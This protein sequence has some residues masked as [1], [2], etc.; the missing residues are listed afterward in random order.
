[1]K[2]FAEDLPT[3][4]ALATAA[5]AAALAVVRISGADAIR[6]ADAL[7]GGRAADA[8]EREAVLC[9]ARDASG[10][11]LDDVLMTVFHAPRSYTGE[12]LVEISGHGGMLVSRNLLARVIEC[13]AA[14][15]GPGEFTQRAFLN[16]KLDLTQA[17]AVMDIIS[18]QTDLGLRAAREQLAGRIGVLVGAAREALLGVVAHVEAHID[19]PEE[20]IDPGTGAEICDKI[21]R[22]SADI[23]RLM[24]TAE[25]GRILRE[26][27]RT[28]I[29]G[30]PNV[31]KSSLLNRLL[32]YER[33]IVSD[34][35]GTTRDTIED[36]VQV[37]GIP[38]RLVDTAGVRHADDVIE[39]EGVVR[40][41]RE[42]DSAELLLEVVDASR[43]PDE[44][45]PVECAPGCRRILVLNKWDLG[46][47]PGWA[48]AGGC[49]LSCREDVGFP[50]LEE[51]I[52]GALHFGADDWGSQAVAVNVRHQA[53]LRRAHDALAAALGAM[54][55]WR[56]SPEFAAVELREALDA[57]GEITGRIDTEDILGVIFSTFCIGK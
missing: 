52:R 9:K 57:L 6:V 31:G 51:A 43:A 2:S 49:R 19:F 24:A 36:V 28:V 3:V 13:G 40:A 27:V 12:N 16:G 37:A 35:P 47:H 18:A 17:E 10:G 46:G 53:C 22:V 45:S 5:G 20:D 44:A 21:R 1:M 32:G 25:R 41:M 54:E 26:G 30:A 48:G 50:E 56:G 8:R 42:I 55:E 23:M 38:L 29:C 7:T 33:A 4:A 15:A 14:P 39:R 34:L 11:V